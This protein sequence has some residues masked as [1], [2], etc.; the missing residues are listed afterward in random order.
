[1]RRHTS[2]VVLLL[3]LAVIAIFL[4][5]VEANPAMAQTQ[6]IGAWRVET[7][8]VMDG[9]A[10]EWQSILPIF[11]PT[12]SQ[13]VAPPMGGGA[14]ERIGVRAVHHDE[15]IY[16]MLEW[17]DVTTDEASDRYEAF[18][19]AAAIQ[20][21]AEAGSEV[22]FLC[23]GQADQAV[24]IWQWRAD[25]QQ[26]PPTLPDN[27]YVDSYPSTE[28]LYYTARQAGNPLSQVDGRTGVANLVAGGFGTLEVTER[29]DLQGNAVYKDGRWM[30][31][32]SRPFQPT[33]DLQP[34]IDGVGPID[35]AFAVW[36]GSEGE[37]DGIKSV[38][39][40]TRLQVTPED[41]PRRAIGATDDWPAYTPSNPM[42]TVSVGFLALLI[43]LM[44]GL[45]I[46]MRGSV[47]EHEDA[48]G[49]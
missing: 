6:S 33:G 40:F 43:V 25:Q 2:P 32:F 18:S 11:L 45:W 34:I 9:S 30:V 8:P 19:D 44:V 17:S 15:R 5:V 42:L 47:E 28:D 1:M 46:Y 49:T 26:G 20:F 21:P 3:A 16:V 12:T 10:P 41:P 13:Q 29:G 36:N 27:G 24:N 23:M 39:A 4:R 48:A 37:R 22:P 31:V 14:I 35:V 7:E 38:S